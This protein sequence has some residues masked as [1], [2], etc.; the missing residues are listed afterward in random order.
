MLRAILFGV[1][2]VSGVSCAKQDKEQ[3]AQVETAAGRVVEVTGK[4]TATRGGKPARELAVGGDVF[5]DDTIDTGTDGAVVVELF[6]NNARWSVEGKQARV[7]ESLAWKLAKQDPV[8][9]PIDHATS[10][11]GRDGERQGA[12]TRVTADTAAQSTTTAP[13]QDA[14]GDAGKEGRNRGKTGGAQKGGSKDPGQPPQAV[15]G[16]E[17]NLDRRPDP[18][19]PPQNQTTPPTAPRTAID[20][21]TQVK[22]AVEA[23][24][25]ELR[26]CL[27]SPTAVL[28]IK[29]VLAGGVAKVEVLGVAN[30]KAKTCVEAIA[31]KLSYPRVD[32]ETTVILK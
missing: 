17:D 16:S 31:R 4:A 23:E 24:R 1:L 6:H 9:K 15:K 32:L 5:R 3:P 29:I 22:A 21:A 28:T 12:G 10:S 18:V 26:A 7:D 13:K 25:K 27:D 20:P 8:A 30:A 11:A 2:L 19:T 14:E